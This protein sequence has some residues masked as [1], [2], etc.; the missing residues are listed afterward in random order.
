VTFIM[1]RMNILRWEKDPLLHN[2]KLERKVQFLAL[3]FI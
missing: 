2:T 3:C 1:D